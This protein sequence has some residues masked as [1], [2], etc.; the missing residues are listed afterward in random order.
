MGG[1]A[2]YVIY[3]NCSEGEVMIYQGNSSTLMVCGVSVRS[4]GA[5]AGSF[6]RID[7]VFYCGL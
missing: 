1:S 2:N 3:N 7:V 5:G 4:L 6:L